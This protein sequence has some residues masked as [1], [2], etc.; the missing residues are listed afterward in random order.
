MIAVLHNS[1]SIRSIWIKH[2]SSARQYLCPRSET[3]ITTD[4]GSV[5]R[6]SNP[7]EGNGPGRRVGTSKGIL[8]PPTEGRS[9]YG[10]GKEK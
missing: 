7:L 5:I 4:F 10:L 9:G 6:G 1:L 3:D 2:W 8:F